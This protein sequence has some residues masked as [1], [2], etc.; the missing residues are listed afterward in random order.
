MTV[1]YVLLAAL[2]LVLCLFAGPLARVLGIVNVPDG[3]RKIHS[4]ET[5]LTG[6]LAIMLPVLI[7][8]VVMTRSTDFGPFYTT[9]AAGLGFFLVFG[10]IDDRQHIRPLWRLAISVA[11]CFVLL[12]AVPALEL[13]FLKLSFLPEAIF[14]EGGAAIF[15]VLCLVGLQN[16]VNMADGKNGLVIGLALIW[17]FALLLFGP[18]HLRPLFIVFALGLAIALPFNLRG[19]LFLGDSGTYAI[20]IVIGLTTIYAYNVNFATLPADIVVL[21]FLIP[22]VDCLRLMVT[23]VIAGRSPLNPDRNHLHHILWQLMPWPGALAAYLA[24][25]AA[26]GLLAALQPAWTLLWVVFALSSYVA[27]IGLTLRGPAA[28]RITSF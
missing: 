15:T 14:L 24:L 23:R 10:L 3:A 18:A 5:P 17:V 9:L 21:W 1:F 11:A 2:T 6:G 20:S 22:V 25:V 26:P 16:A 7:V 12:Y 28:R 27:I 19:V 13:S 8:A 4:R